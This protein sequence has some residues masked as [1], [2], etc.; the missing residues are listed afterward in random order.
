MTRSA[1]VLVFSACIGAGAQTARLEFEA[2]AIRPAPPP[3]NSRIWGCSGGPG[4]E[5]PTRF[6]C[7]RALLSSI[8]LMAYQVQWYQL[9]APD[10][11]RDLQVAFDVQAKVPEKATR[12]E[13]LVMLQNMLADRFKMVAHHES[14]ETDQYDLVVGKNGPKFKESPP[15][16]AE[17]TRSQ[18]PALPNG[19]SMARINGRTAMSIL[20]SNISSQLRT[21]VR[22]MT[23]LTAK[24]YDVTICWA[25]ESAAP[26]AGPT[27]MEALQDQLGLRLESRKAPVDFIVV[28][29]AEKSPTA[30]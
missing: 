5:D 3:D 28:D 16:P 22:D 23:G 12:N 2:T 30:N 6:V 24:Y 11:M 1:A 20:V 18:C 25:P 17:P 26:D 4:R 21:P 7:E 14:R 15:G 19:A 29:H 8:V 13:F 9:S 10:W 27:L